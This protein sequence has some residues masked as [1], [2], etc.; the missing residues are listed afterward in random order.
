[1]VHINN[2]TISF[3]DCGVGKCKD[4]DCAPGTRTHK[5]R[6]HSLVDDRAPCV[7]ECLHSVLTKSRNFAFELNKIAN[8]T[9]FVECTSVLPS[10]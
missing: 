3:Y 1:M 2:H 6:S 8:M 7:P 10:K 9:S 5:I 4:I